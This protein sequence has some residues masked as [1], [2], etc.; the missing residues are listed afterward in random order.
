MLR[1]NISMLNL[2]VSQLPQWM[3]HTNHDVIGLI[4]EVKA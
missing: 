4:Q 2:V 1:R 3:M